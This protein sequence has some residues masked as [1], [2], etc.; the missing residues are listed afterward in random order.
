MTVSVVIAAMGREQLRMFGRSITEVSSTLGVVGPLII[1]G[2]I[3]AIG[4]GGGYS[5]SAL[6]AAPTSTSA[7]STRA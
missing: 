1:L 7:S 4:L 2:W 5:N 6:G 3:V